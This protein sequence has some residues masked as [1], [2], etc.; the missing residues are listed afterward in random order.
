MRQ[1]VLTNRSSG[2]VFR[3]ASLPAEVEF[4]HGVTSMKI[5]VDQLGDMSWP[6][7]RTPTEFRFSGKFWGPNRITLPFVDAGAYRLPQDCIE[8][9]ETWHDAQYGA[10][11]SDAKPQRLN[12]VLTGSDLLEDVAPIIKDVYISS[13][14]HK[15]VGGMG[16]IEYDLTLTEWRSVTILQDVPG[17]PAMETAPEGEQPAES[18]PDT[19]PVPSS[20]TVQEGDTLSSLANRLLGDAARWP[21][22]YDIPENQETIGGDPDLLQPG[23]L[24]LIPGGQDL[25]E[26]DEE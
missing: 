24:L 10:G 26:D 11:T 18:D 25:Q 13:F 14:T 7:G 16:D 2:D 19:P 6:S 15:L 9:L 4:N 12:L 23:Q 1:L 5:S 20:Y 3:F 17:T 22:I 8:V 21:E